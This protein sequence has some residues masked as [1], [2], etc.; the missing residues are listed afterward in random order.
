MSGRFCGATR[1]VCVSTEINGAT[2]SA[3]RKLIQQRR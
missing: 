1:Q 3:P 2:W